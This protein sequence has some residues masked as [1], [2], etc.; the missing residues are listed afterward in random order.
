MRFL[1][2]R[3]L[4]HSELGVFH[5][6]RRQRKEGSK[7]RAVNFDW[8]VVDRVFPAA[9][10][11]D[12]VEM[13]LRYD[14]DS[15]VAT[16]RQWLKRQEK[17]WRL[18]GN[19]PKDKCYHFVD[20]GCLFA[21]EIDAGT[22]P[23]SG[24]WAVFPADDPVTKAILADGESS[25]LAKSA[26]IALHDKEG[27]RTWKVLNE[28]RPDLFSAPARNGTAAVAAI[29]A[30][31]NGVKLPPNPSRLVKMLARV[32]HTMPSA[33]ADLVDNAISADA[34]KIAIT[35][36]R[37]D[38]GHGRW[39]S[40][41]DNG[42]GMDQDKLAEAMR[43]GSD[44]EYEDNSL[45]KYGFGLKGASWAQADVFTVVTKCEGALAHHLTWDVDDMEEWTAKTDPLGAWESE[46]TRLEKHGTVVLWKDMRP[47]QAVQTARGVDPH[48]A[49]IMQLERHLAL[50]F[51]RF[52]EGKALG[53]KTVTLTINGKKVQPNNPFGHPLASAYD[54]KF[55]R[56]PTENG[57]GR[58][59]VQ[60]YLLPT[61]DEISAYHKAEGPEAIRSA[62]DLIGLH[63]K[64]NETQG[65]F[66][67][68]HD[69]LIKWGG[70]HQMWETNDEKTK[71]ARVIVDFDKD[72]DDAFKINISKQHVQL[73][74]QLQA[75]I[76]KLADVARKDSQR[77]YRREARQHP[78]PPPAPPA[79][80][81][82]SKTA[83]TVPVGGGPAPVP[84][85]PTSGP[86]P[87]QMP[88]GPAPRVVVKDVKTDKF[89]WKVTKG[90]TGTLD[91]QVSEL[92][93][94]LS[95]LVNHIR[96]DPHAVAYLAAFLGG[97]DEMDVQKHLLAKKD[98]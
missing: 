76:K 21:M 27:E 67:Y 93:S 56:I 75:E 94:S 53:R 58:V 70:W 95:A 73:S 4:T 84:T 26:M 83:G 10:D 86:T 77:K 13:D 15:G 42:S 97:L 91:V 46:V 54:A 80:G 50:V 63:G 51:H 87:P 34:T 62:L 66:V 1:I 30:G 8:D 72:L 9:K 7:Q 48:T 71:L 3:I 37:P 44:S 89:V 24:A 22:S 55:I 85:P 33:V 12:L 92:D 57:D 52:L 35:F 88:P 45:G 41:A 31:P 6:Y 29:K 25:K 79:P 11:S 61:E 28:T 49:E 2:L 78:V 39:M 40:I 64:R 14:T 16:A 98:V 81:T 23:A 59:K 60:A 96:P 36:Q 82:G 19:C 17:N 69:R 68:R 43:I 74:Q 65:L 90:M 38:G 5:E 20:P 47:P 32:G 18:E